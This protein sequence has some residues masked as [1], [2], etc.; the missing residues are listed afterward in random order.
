MWTNV[1]R[2]FQFK[3]WCKGDESNIKNSTDHFCE[4]TRQNALAALTNL[5]HVTPFL[6]LGP[7]H[8]LTI[9]WVREI[10]SLDSKLPDQTEVHIRSDTLAE[11]T[12]SHSSRTLFA[13][14]RHCRC[15]WKTSTIRGV[16]CSPL[17]KIVDL[18]VPLL[19]VLGSKG[20]IWPLGKPTPNAYNHCLFYCFNLFIIWRSNGWL[21]WED[22]PCFS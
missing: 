17:S 9:Q 5:G 13:Q 2:T 22:H 1:K 11:K 19:N 8:H 3:T 21:Q 14:Q 4:D 20:K 16:S 10:T 7:P 12:R 18:F 6:L 15:C